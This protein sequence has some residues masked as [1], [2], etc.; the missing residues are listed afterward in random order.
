MCFWPLTAT[1]SQI[2][3][4]AS[5]PKARLTHGY[6]GQHLNKIMQIARTAGRCTAKQLPQQQ[7]K[8]LLPLQTFY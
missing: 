5:A 6:L 7:R 2:S 4:W 3:G 1:N 8:L